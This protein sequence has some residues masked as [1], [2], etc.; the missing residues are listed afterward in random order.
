[1]VRV[2]FSSGV[3]KK[4]TVLPIKFRV[5]VGPG[6]M[7]GGG[8]LEEL[9]NRKEYIMDQYGMLDT[10]DSDFSWKKTRVN[11]NFEAGVIV[12]IKQPSSPAVSIGLSTGIINAS[13]K[14]IAYSESSYTEQPEWWGIRKVADNM[15][16]TGEYQIR[17]IPI[18]L[19]F[20]LSWPQKISVFGQKI[21]PSVYAGIGYYFGKM[22]HDQTQ[23]YHY[24]LRAESGRFYDQETDFSRD[25]DINEE[26]KAGSLG[27]RGG[28]G[29]EVEVSSL[30]SIG[31]EIFGRI[32]NFTNWEGDRTDSWNS[33]ERY[34]HEINGWAQ[35][36]FDSGRTTENGFLWKYNGVNDILNE[37]FMEMRISENKPDSSTFF[38]INK[39]AINLNTCGFQ[40]AI[41]FSLPFLDNVLRK[42]RE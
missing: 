39:A 18:L 17:A 32:V 9:R 34:Y 5:A 35:D 3:G 19:D 29:F 25:R 33:T 26:M 7:N 12:N 38:D 36:V 6:F 27:F 16:T 20:R 21:S 15:D 13:A 14:D 1:M 24:N 22:I 10:A 37:Q 4:P 30:I 42:D 31:V 8:D 2:G 28:L 11:S 41:N 40:I 23:I